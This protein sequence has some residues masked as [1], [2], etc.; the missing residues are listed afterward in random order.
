MF[1]GA[2]AVVYRNEAGE[3][4]GWD[5]PG[6]YEPDLDAFYDDADTRDYGDT[7]AEEDDFECEGH[8]SL[9]GAHM[10]KTVYCDGSCGGS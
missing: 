1:P 8:D 4:L 5:Y 3:P 9:G 7:E 6:E 10:G 2:G